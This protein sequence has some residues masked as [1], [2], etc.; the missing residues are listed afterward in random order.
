MPF[1]LQIVLAQVHDL[2]HYSPTRNCVKSIRKKV[3]EGKKKRLFSVTE[4]LD[5][6]GVARN[7]VEC[8]RNQVVFTQGDPADSV[9]YIQKGGVKLSVVSITGKEAV[10]AIL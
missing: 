1:H 4:F 2:W 9:L 10:V 6:A 3:V 7:V 8:A 5:S